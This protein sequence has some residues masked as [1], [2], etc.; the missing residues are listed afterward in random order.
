MRK[1][2]ILCLHGGRSNNDVTQFQTA[3]LK[4]S[5]RAD[6]HYLHAPHEAN[7]C[8]PGLENFVSPPFWTWSEASDSASEQW[9]K[10]L[11]SIAEY[12]R[13]EGPF[14]AVFG[15]SQGAAM[16]TQFS[17]PS[18]WKERFG[19]RSCPWKSAILACGGAASNVANDYQAKIDIPSLHI[20]GSADP[21]LAES[22]L[23]LERWTD[24]SART[25]THQKG[26]EIDLMILS[27]EEELAI[28]LD[29]FLISM[30]IF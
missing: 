20:M 4:L 7:R 23:L 27:R 26:H 29:E 8:Y 19:F 12:C 30:S 10:S 15:F 16:I 22:K 9:D 13:K 2:K 3:G 6:C 14:D 28:V 24:G 5:T 18:I 11:E 17:Y 1:S 25:Y 21:Y